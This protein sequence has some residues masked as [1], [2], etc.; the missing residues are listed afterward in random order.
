MEL[1]DVILLLEQNNQFKQWQK[2]HTAY[3]LAH[4]FVMLDE[5]NVDIWQIGF[6]DAQKNLMTTFFVEK[7]EVKIIPDQEVLKSDIEIVPLKINEVKISSLEAMKIACDVFKKE[8]ANVNVIKTFF[9][10]Q[11]IKDAAVYNV[12]FFTRAF[13]S[14]NVKIAAVDGKIL[15]HSESSLANFS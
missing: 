2:A 8:F 9:I 4:A 3:F 5:F 13:K 10:I 1:K 12:T 11:Q 7:S 14:L 15:H 6:F